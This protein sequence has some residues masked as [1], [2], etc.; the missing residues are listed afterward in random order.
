MQRKFLQKESGT[1]L[2]EFALVL[3][4]LI[5]LLFGII[6]FGFIIYDKAMIT[7]ASREGARFGTVYRLSAPGTYSPPNPTEIQN[8]I[9]KYL[10]DTSGRN[11]LISF[12]N[13]AFGVELDPL[14]GCPSSGANLR[15]TVKYGYH[16]LVLPNFITSLIDPLQLHAETVMRCE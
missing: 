11:F 16:F 9:N 14:N 3:P 12:P 8:R 7:N 4:L 10:E 13:N 6:E 1:S 5:V 2:V 15:V